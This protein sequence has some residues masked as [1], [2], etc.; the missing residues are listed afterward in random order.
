VL[1]GHPQ[2]KSVSYWPSFHQDAAL[3]LVSSSLTTWGTLEAIPMLEFHHRHMNESESGWIWK[4]Q[5]L[6]K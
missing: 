5:A 2:L 6:F 3:N 4:A 1:E